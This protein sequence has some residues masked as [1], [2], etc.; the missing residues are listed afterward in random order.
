VFIGAYFLASSLS[1][2]CLSMLLSEKPL[3]TEGTELTP[4]SLSALWNALFGVTSAIVLAFLFGSSL[5]L[6]V[7]AKNQEGEVMYHFRL[8]W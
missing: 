6:L 7:T 3:Q 1:R 4:L 8:I 5:Y 2:L